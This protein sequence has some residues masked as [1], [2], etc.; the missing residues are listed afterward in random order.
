MESDPHQTDLEGESAMDGGE[1]G[2]RGWM[3]G[4]T[5]TGLRR[6]TLSVTVWFDTSTCNRRQALFFIITFISVGVML[7]FTA[8][9]IQ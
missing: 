3:T 9:E 6:N 8:A 5:T 1:R 2:M 7:V 4:A